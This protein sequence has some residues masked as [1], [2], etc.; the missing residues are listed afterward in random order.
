[1]KNLSCTQTALRV[2]QYLLED[3]SLVLHFGH[4]TEF[5]V[6]VQHG[7]GLEGLKEQ[8]FVMSQA[9]ANQAVLNGSSGDTS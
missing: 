1:M 7:V 5:E 9:Q 8:S 3:S 4:G 2:L 6:L